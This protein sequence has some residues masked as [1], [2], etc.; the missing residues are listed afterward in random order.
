M[1]WA[2]LFT[3]FLIS[4]PV[5]CII[6]A[7]SALTGGRLAEAIKES[8]TR[9]SAYHSFYGLCRH[10]CIL[11][12]IL[13][14]IH[15]VLDLIA[16]LA[17]HDA[18]LQ[19]LFLREQYALENMELTLQSQDETRRSRHE[20]LHHL[21]LI[22]E[23]L[24]RKEQ[25]RA[26]EYVQALLN[27]V[28]AIPSDAWSDNLVVNAIAGRY[29]NA[30]R[31]EGVKV[32]GDI[33]ITGDLPLADGALCV[34]LTNMLE[35][36]LEACISIP[37]GTERFILFRMKALKGHLNICCK[38]STVGKILSDSYPGSNKKDSSHHGYGIAA[39]HDI[40][41]KHNGQFTFSCIDGCF[42]VEALI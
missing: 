36:A 34:L 14:F 13:C 8:F 29:L 25:E 26:S 39:M 42:T 24:S 5:S 22:H 21:S 23:L 2:S 6:L 33:R 35:N 27:E 37:D 18:Q 11:L 12:L 19:A 9:L 1:A 4:L 15:A 10:L 41:E 20:M 28:S 16:Q 31:K 7:A 3:Y 30:A 17:R 32:T 38:N 40:I